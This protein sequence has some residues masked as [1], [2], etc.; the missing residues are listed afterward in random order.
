ML[1]SKYNLVRDGLYGPSLKRNITALLLS[2]MQYEVSNGGNVEDKQGVKRVFFLAN[3][4][5]N[6]P[7]EKNLTYDRVESIMGFIFKN[8]DLIRIAE[9]RRMQENIKED[10]QAQVKDLV[11]AEGRD[12]IID[13]VESWVNEYLKSKG[14]HESHEMS[15]TPAEKGAKK[16][17][18][19]INDRLMQPG[20]SK[21]EDK[22][23]GE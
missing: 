15:V 23:I 5:G 12:K 17:Q 7:G 13:I 16:T 8:Y 19:K 6:I 18:N 4:T 10:E 22:E 3:L 20:K 9:E 1:Q 14:I 11:P 2:V 21:E